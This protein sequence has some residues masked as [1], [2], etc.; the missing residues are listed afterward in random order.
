MASFLKNIRATTW[1]VLMLAIVVCVGASWLVNFVVG[2]VGG[3]VRHALDIVERDTG[4]LVQ[5]PLLAGPFYFAIV[6][7]VIFGIGRLRF[8]DV[9]WRRRDVGPGLLVTLGFWVA[10][11]PA[12]V[13]WVL[14]TGG[15]LQWNAAWNPSSD[16]GP[17]RILG[18][19]LAQLLGNALLEEMVFRG[20]FLP[21]FYLK[22]A[23]RFRPAAALLIALLGSQVLFALTHIPNRLFVQGWPVEALLG[24]Q[25]V[26]FLHG[27]IYSVVYLL[28][29]ILFVCVG[30]HSLWNQPARLLQV[31]FEPG[32]AIV[33]FMLTAIL[34]LTWLPVRRRWG[35]SDGDTSA[36]AQ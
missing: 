6:G 12:L 23:A 16:W 32:V 13:I 8:S 25:V 19:L 31:P 5:A 34:V 10:M 4:G 33:W 26:L 11:Q 21:Q 29:R 24:D 2:P 27:L 35:R 17:G 3:N 22:A 1:P 7:T 14:V 20:F 18:G 15:Q 9:G 36:R 30:L 28:T